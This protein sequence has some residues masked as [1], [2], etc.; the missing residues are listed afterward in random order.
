[1][2]TIGKIDTL[3]SYYLFAKF[4]RAG[5]NSPAVARHGRIGA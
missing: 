4:A 5:K 1:M 2:Q 3:I